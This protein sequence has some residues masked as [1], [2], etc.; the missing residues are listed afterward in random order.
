[1]TEQS[2]AIASGYLAAS[3]IVDYHHPLV[4]SQAQALAEGV[5]DSMAL[6]RRCYEF[7]RDDIPHSFDINSD[8]VSC[9]ASEVLINGHGICYAQS[10]LLAALLRANGIP[11][12]FDYQRLYDDELNYCLHGF[13]TV[14]L[15]EFGWYRIDA[16]GNTGDID[17]RFCPPKERLAFTTNVSGEIDYNLNLAEPLPSVVRALQDAETIEALRLGLPSSIPMG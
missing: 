3:A 5:A 7:V 8:P 1:M 10:H 4:K 16:R 15:P 12:G 6:T 9:T 11:T 17:A 2:N 14:Y 13:N